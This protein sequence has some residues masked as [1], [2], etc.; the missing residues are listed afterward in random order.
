MRNPKIKINKK[1]LSWA[2]GN[3]GYE[4]IAFYDISPKEFLLLTC[5][6]YAHMNLLI[7][8]AKDPEI[9][10]SD[11]FQEGIS[12]HPFLSISPDGRVH[13]HEGRHRAASE[14]V[15]K[16]PFYRIVLTAVESD[17]PRAKYGPRWH[18]SLPVPRFLLGQF[19]RKVVHEI[20]Q[21]RITL[22]PP[23]YNDKESNPYPQDNN[24]PP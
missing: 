20:D 8:E 1:Q 14:L 2:T 24:I 4:A 23:Y 3:G 9:W 11:E 17:Y 15:A 12:V 16:E 18:R 7:K 6:D 22:V 13:A 19:M 21:D 10:N 5:E